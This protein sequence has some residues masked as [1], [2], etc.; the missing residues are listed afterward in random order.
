MNSPRLHNP[1]VVTSSVGV[2][3]ETSARLQIAR[4]FREKQQRGK[5]ARGSDHSESNNKIPLESLATLIDYCNRAQFAKD[6]LSSCSASR[7]EYR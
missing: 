5:S 1:A 2:K 3:E 7:N 6:F 4:V